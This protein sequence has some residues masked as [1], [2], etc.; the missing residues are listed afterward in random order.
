MVAKWAALLS[1][2]V[3]MTGCGGTKEAGGESAAKPETAPDTFRVSLETSK[4]D[5]VVEVTKAWAPEGAERFYLLVKRGFYDECRFFRVLRD[6]VVQFGINGDPAVSSRWRT[7]TIADDPVK[8]SNKRGTVTFATS[9][10][11]TRTTQVFINL[12]DNVRLDSMGF[13]PFGKVIS[14]MEV[15]DRFFNSYG[16]GAPRGSGPD[17][18]LIE[19]QGNAYL[20]RSFPRLD[21]IKK[22]RIQ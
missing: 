3:F 2:L 16:E 11:N 19:T 1:M 5:V 8:E 22:A 6:F 21:Y 9:G 4:G 14:G 15:V 7:A 12:A 18:Q 13:A 17:Q 10:P 20:E